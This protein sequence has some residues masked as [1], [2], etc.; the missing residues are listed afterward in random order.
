LIPYQPGLGNKVLRVMLPLGP[1]I[2]AFCAAYWIL[3][4]RELSMLLR[5]GA[6]SEGPR[7]AD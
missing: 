6:S 5:G 3:G 7:D 2:A 4:G 1:A